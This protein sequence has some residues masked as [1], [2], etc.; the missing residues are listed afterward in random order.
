VRVAV[1]QQPPVL[2]DRAATLRAAITHLEAAAGAGAGLVVFPETFIPGYPAWI[3]RLRPGD[4]HD[5]TGEIHQQ[6]VENSVDLAA[7][8]L[9][10]LR[11][12]ASELHLVVVCGI[13]ERDGAF[14]RSTLYNTVVTIG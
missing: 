9:K 3:W 6:L 4:D 1:V 8:G 10:S 13:H 11:D 14:G 2:L 12:A 7:D 5:L